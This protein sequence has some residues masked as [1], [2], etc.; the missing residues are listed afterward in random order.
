MGHCGPSWHRDRCDRSCPDRLILAQG[1]GGAGQRL[2]CYALKNGQAAVCR[3]IAGGIASRIAFEIFPTP[4][5][6][7][8]FLCSGGFVRIAWAGLITYRP[9]RLRSMAGDRG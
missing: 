9:H 2:V 7:M 5:K 8:L 1:E 6:Y 3:A 4:L